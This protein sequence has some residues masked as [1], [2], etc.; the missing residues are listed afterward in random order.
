MKDFSDLVYGNQL[1]VPTPKGPKRYINF[2][3][4]A[5]TPPFKKVMQLL[6]ED[7]AW[8]ASVHRGTGYKS[9]LTTAKYDAAR[10][11]V[12]R[13]LGYDPK[14]DVVIFT[15]NT[16]E[17]LNKV[18][19]YLPYLPGELIIYTLLEHHSNELPWQDYPCLRLESRDNQLDL[20]ELER[21]LKLH[22][23]RVKLL[24][25][26]GA[27]NV[28]GYTPPINTLA[29]MA[30]D[31]GAMILVDAAQLVPHRPVNILPA[32]NPRHLDFLAFSGHK[33]YAPFGA[34]ALIGPRWL[35]NKTPPSQVGG[36]II[37]GIGPA[38]IIWAL[39]PEVEEAGSPN[40]LG[41]L[42]IAH[43]FEVLEGLGWN[44]LINHETDLLNHALRQLATLPEVVLY[45]LGLPNQVGVVSLNIRGL[46]HRRVAQYLAEAGGV[47]VRNGCFCARNFVQSLLKLDQQ[48]LMIAQQHIMQG[49]FELAPGMV[50]I[51][52]GCYNKRSEID[53]VVD[54][55]R[56][57]TSSKK[58]H[59]N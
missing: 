32:D 31:A 50:R 56:N 12:G 14:H 20:D 47:G 4:A 23:G 57:L 38:G 10:E 7:A 30:H 13:F 59:L 22:R 49:H 6:A 8:Y 26:T 17:G 1:K 51:S 45:N 25:V 52:F 37:K 36:G 33:V 24:A 27:S 53:L 48:E 15:K 58:D 9:Q 21:L 54:L 2:D 16:T 11:T 19:H 39:A 34:G 55:L 46:H 42:A 3:N 41:A 18:R 43:A 44:D 5:S 28:T 35:F 29:E 40:V